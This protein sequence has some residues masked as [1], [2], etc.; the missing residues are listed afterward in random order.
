MYGL[1]YTHNKFA[2]PWQSYSIRITVL[3]L[4]PLGVLFLNQSTVWYSLWVLAMVF[5]NFLLD[6][7]F[8][9]V[10][11]IE[12]RT[13]KRKVYKIPIQLDGPNIRKLSTFEMSQIVL[14]LKKLQQIDREE[15]HEAASSTKMRILNF[16]TKIPDNTPQS[17]GTPGPQRIK[18]ATILNVMST[19]PKET[20]HENKNSG[21]EMNQVNQIQPKL[22]K[23]CKK[24]LENT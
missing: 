21:I 19:Q 12:V 22:R 4:I 1:R 2:F 23:L 13:D 20:P 11:S 3:M 15:E 9:E 8:L 24:K 16:K 10:I 17:G 14:D 6:H 18:E 7:L 5:L